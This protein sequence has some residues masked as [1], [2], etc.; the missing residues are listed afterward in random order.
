MKENN[1]SFSVSTNGLKHDDKLPDNPQ[2]KVKKITA[3]NWTLLTV[4]LKPRQIVYKY[5][6]TK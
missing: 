5:N 4:T 2:A 1:W 6:E 3:N